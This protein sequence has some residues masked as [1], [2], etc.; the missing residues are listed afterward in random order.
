MAVHALDLAEWKM[1]NAQAEYESAKNI[2]IE[3][4]RIPADD[5]QKKDLFITS[6]VSGFLASGRSPILLKVLAQAA[7]RRPDTRL[8]IARI[9]GEVAGTAALAFFSTPFGRV[10]ELYLDSTLPA[11]QGR[12]VQ[13]ALLRARLDVAKSEGCGTAVVTAR[14]GSGSA[15]NAVRVGFGLVYTRETFTKTVTTSL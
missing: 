9:D 1:E 14:P 11:Y 12:G 10:A 15:R 6:A 5:T 7:T 8:Y 3:I 2:D 13:S 4:T